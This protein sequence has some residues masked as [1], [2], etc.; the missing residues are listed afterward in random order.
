MLHPNLDLIQ[1][2]TAVLVKGF[3]EWVAEVYQVFQEQKTCELLPRFRCVLQPLPADM[4]NLLI[5]YVSGIL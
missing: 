4:A 1:L 2:T 5:S 3:K